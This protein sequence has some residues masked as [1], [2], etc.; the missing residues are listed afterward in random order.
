MIDKPNKT[1]DDKEKHLITFAII[2]YNQEK[3]IQEAV[4]GAF[5]QTYSPLEIILSDDF[6]KDK[7]FDII[8]AMASA[9]RGPHKI[10]L[11]R[12]EENLGICGHVNKVLEMSS[13]DL[14]ILAAGDDIS[15]PDRARMSWELLEKNRDCS[16]LSFSTIVFNDE[17]NKKEPQVQQVYSCVKYS[18]DDL[19]KNCEFHINGASRTIRKSVL[20][21]FGPLMPETPTEDSTILLRCLLTG[22]VLE[23]KEPQVFYRVH[24][25]NF[26]A[27]NK[28]SIDYQKIHCQ[29]MN[30]LQIALEIGLIKDDAFKRVK[31]SL[32]T[33]LQRRKLW[34]EFYR[35]DKKIKNFIFSILFSRVFHPK[36][37]LK[38]F[39]RALSEIR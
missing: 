13:S 12:N 33:K 34:S 18:I 20:E 16:C 28:Y 8:E 37:K 2:A 30:D 11:N 14:L 21:R 27:S 24:G 39:K 9:Y 17:Y 6:S 10:I 35:N 19:M 25:D 38:Y 26:Y 1:N 31:K 5:S 23:S 32:Q 15:M 29:Y 36:E 3:F 7:T 4:E 22:A